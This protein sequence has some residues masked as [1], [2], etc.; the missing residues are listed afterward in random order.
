MITVLLVTR[1]IPIGFLITAYLLSVYVMLL[2]NLR[3]LGAHRYTSGGHEG[4]FMDQLLDSIN[5]PRHPLLSSLW[6][7]IG[8]RFH[9]LHHLFPSLPYHNLATAHERLMAELPADS[10]YRQ[11]VSDGLLVSLSQLWS[12]PG[13]E[14][15]APARPRP[16]R[17]RRPCTA[18]RRIRGAERR[19]KSGVRTG[20][21]FLAVVEEL[22]PEIE[23]LQGLCGQLDNVAVH[24]DDRLVLRPSSDEV[25]RHSHRTECDILMGWVF[26][27]CFRPRQPFIQRFVV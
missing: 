26:F 2:N 15:P 3:T 8:L 25:R 17:L 4:S 12:Q 11:T 9:A 6:G 13:R 20:N 19:P 14:R 22:L 18:C 10:P 21:Q 16:R 5:Y 1:T 24:S 23:G 27:V 7:P